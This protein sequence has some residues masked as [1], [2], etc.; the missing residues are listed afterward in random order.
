MSQLIQKLKIKPEPESKKTVQV[1]I[2]RK[3]KVLSDHEDTTDKSELEQTQVQ[4]QKD[5]VPVDIAEES[6]EHVE[7]LTESEDVTKAMKPGITIIDKRKTGFNR[8]DLLKRLREKGVIAPSFI[9]S[10]PS[11]IEPQ[12]KKKT[13]LP[14]KKPSD[15]DVDTDKPVKIKVKKLKGKKLKLS[16]KITQGSITAT[17]AEKPVRKP[18]AKDKKLVAEA[19]VAIMK[20]GDTNIQDRISKKL[21]TIIKAPQYYMNNRQAFVQFINSIFIKYKDEI[22]DQSKDVS[23]E[24][25]KSDGDFEPMPHQKI[26]RDYLSLYTPYRGL[27]LYH[28]LG[29]GKTCSSIGIAEG[30]KTRNQVIIMTPASLRMNYIEQ[31]KECGDDLYKKNQYWEFINTEDNPEYID[32]LSGALNLEREYIKKNGGAWLINITKPSNYGDLN[33]DEKES[34]NNQINRMMQAKYKFI[35]YNGLRMSHIDTLSLDGSINP[36]DNKV[37]IIDEA[38]NFISRIV[39]KINSSGSISM[40]LYEYLLSARNCR[41]VLLTGTPIINYPNEIGILFNILRG[42]IKTW[43]IP[44]NVK[45]D[46]KVNVDT[47]RKIFEGEKMLDYLEYKPSSKTIIV[48]KNPFG[49]IN[50]RRKVRGKDE[51][52]YMGVRI[53][54]D[55]DMGNYE[56]PD[57]EIYSDDTFERYIFTKL[58]DHDIDVI[59]S[60]IRVENFKALPDKLDEFKNLFVKNNG[61]IQNEQMFKNRIIGLTSYFKSA[62]E[63]LLPRYDKSTDM[64]VEKIPMSDYQFGIYEKA[65]EAERDQEKRNAKKRK[66]QTGKADGLYDDTVSTYRIFS[67][68]FCNFVF[69]PE[70]KRPMPNDDE[71]I[72][73]AVQKLDEDDID[74]ATAQERIDNPDGK[75]NKDEV[76]ALQK[77]IAEKEDETYDA[78]IKTALRFLKDNEETYLSETG[79]E[80]YSPKFLSLLQNIQ[81]T[82]EEPT[83]NGLHLIYSQFRTL[84][85]I[86]ILKLVLEANGFTQFR[87][88]KNTTGEWKLAIPDV[89]KGKPT[90]ALYTGTETPEE[91]EIIRNIYNSSWEYVPTSITR[92]L[93]EISRNNHYGEIIKILMITSSGAE[94]IDLK[95]IRHIH[96]MEPY[97]HPVRLEQ[98]IGRGVRICSHKDLPEE[99]R[100]VKVYLYLMTFTEAQKRSDISIEL[101]LKD[102]SKKLYHYDDETK[103]YH[104]IDETN[105][106]QVRG[107]IRIPLS[108]DEALHEIST[109]KDEI[110]QQIIKAIKEASIDCD[111]HSKAGDKEGL[112]CLSYGD[113]VS[114]T[115]MS[116]TPSYKNQSTDVEEQFN[117]EKITWKAVTLKLGDKKYKI[118]LE[119]DGKTRTDMVYD[120]DSFERAKKVP[121]AQPRYIGKL[122]ISGKTAKI[123]ME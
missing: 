89:D 100:N 32:A 87:I 110:N 44:I 43:H 108:S 86:G 19:P 97:W 120:Y 101:R 15:G 35:N 13:K 73:D 27:L 119:D 25:R 10:K 49:F 63:A 60:G 37:I 40:R 50:V 36:F 12:K 51:T 9:G 116:Y 47:L 5:M 96:L 39:N 42:Y 85:G 72:S 11:D 24:T 2:L 48:T 53:G 99:L 57:N 114:S 54:K 66:K 69:P 75:Y 29:S 79:L 46:K 59:R 31:M 64:I 65:R 30:L 78:R 55:V 103:T 93:K 81:E 88:S 62:Q 105:Q 58:K 71:T 34:L 117:R 82:M 61:E 41:I 7:A 76:E 16:T 77:D 92:E 115:K 104:T 91:K 14:S 121:G 98:V 33:A 21:P 67:R 4:Q 26:V 106:E 102:L 109:I 38:H 68:A 95:N 112:I 83:K 8:E 107:A 123:V 111:I 17:A 70:M 28:G 20:I 118:R 1:G 52:K 90:F 18:R 6:D 122:V 80:Q 84:E 23:C 3:K 113:R 45:T 94:G 56:L 74:N 22:E